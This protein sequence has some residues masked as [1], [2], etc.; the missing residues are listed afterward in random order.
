[1]AALR[2]SRMAYTTRLGPRTVSPPPNTPRMSGSNRSPS[3]LDGFGE[4]FEDPGCFFEVD[5]AVG[6]ALAIGIVAGGIVVLAAGDKV[7][8]Q[9]DACDALLACGDLGGEG[10]GDVTLA[11]VVLSFRGHPLILIHSSTSTFG[12]WISST[13]SS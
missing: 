12:N 8:L 5:A 11:G 4:F 3:C 2:P 13:P 7:A 10:S 9:H 6:D 1:M